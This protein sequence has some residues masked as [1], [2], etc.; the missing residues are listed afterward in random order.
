MQKGRPSVY[1]KKG[2]YLNKT[3]DYTIEKEGKTFIV[4]AK[5]YMAYQN[6][7]HLELTLHLLENEWYDP[8]DKGAF[9]LFLELE[10]E[11]PYANYN[12][13]CDEAGGSPFSPDGKIL[14]WSKVKKDEV[15]RI[16]EKYN[17][18]DIFSIEEMINGIKNEKG[19]EYFQFVQDKKSWTNELFDSLLGK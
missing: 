17:F 16:K 18:S 6:F 11:K 4:E 9:Q 19:D 14:I 12:F 8:S 5:C 15:K 10:K 1:N 13:H 3:F 2:R 7:R